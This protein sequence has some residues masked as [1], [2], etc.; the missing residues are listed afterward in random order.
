MD[1][2]RYFIK[3]EGND[4]VAYAEAIKYATNLAVKKS[5]NKIVLLV[6]AKSSTG[7]FERLF[8]DKIVKKLHKGLIDKTNNLIIKIES[9]KTYKSNY[10]N[11]EIVVTCALDSD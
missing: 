10:N 11:S 9:K 3:T 1:K 6:G 7:W 2:E 4:D 8:G 5:I